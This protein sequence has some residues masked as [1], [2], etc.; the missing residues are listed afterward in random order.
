MIRLPD[1][2]RPWALMLLMLA[3]ATVLR[4]VLDP[5]LGDRAPFVTYYP[6]TV[7]LALYAGSWPAAASV[8]LSVIVSGLLFGPAEPVRSDVV[9]LAIYVPV[10][11]ALIVLIERVRRAGEEARRRERAARERETAAAEQ[12]AVLEAALQSVDAGVHSWDPETGEAQWDARLRTLFGLGH[13]EPATRDALLE[14]VHP[15]DRTRVE[16]AVLDATSPGGTRRYTV[17]FRVVRDDGDIRWISSA[18]FGVFDGD[19]LVRLVGTAR[20]VTERR[21][22]EA[23]LRESEQRFATLAEGS[24]V[25]LWVNG[26]AGN[27]FVNRAYREFVGVDS[28]EEISGNDWSRFVHPG[29]RADYFNA[30]QRAFA[31]EGQFTA[32]FRFR[33]RDGEYRW[34]RSDA[35]PRFGDDGELVGY[36]GATVD[37]TE[38]RSAED[39]LRLADRQKD[40]FLAMLAHELRNPLAPIRNASEVLALRYAGD[41]E[42]AVPIA[43]LRRQSEHL[44]RLLDD[45]LDVT[46]IAQGRVALKQQPLEIGT[47]VAQAIETVGPLAQQKSQLVRLERD[48]TPLYVSGDRARLVQSL[49]NVLQNSVKFTQQGGEIVV[50]VRDAGPDLELTVRDNGAGIAPDLVPRVF[51]L[52]VQSERTPDRSQGGLGIGLSVVKRLVEMHGGAVRVTSAGEGRG[53]TVT[54]RLPRIEPPQI[55]V[56]PAHAAS[57]ARRVLV[58]DDSADAADSL[59]MLLELEGHDVSTAYTAAAALDKAERLQPDVAFIDIGLPQMDGYEVARRLRASERCRAIRLVALTGYGQPDDRDEA[60][61]AGFDHHLV[62]PA[63]LESVDA[64]LSES[65]G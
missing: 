30:Y 4:G 18:G 44:A 60:R 17:E 34:M 48:E 3:A 45:L 40:E 31:V 38:R 59:A 7:F 52:F 63:D 27:E 37:I 13:D 57:A 23:A 26:P 64:I 42:A 32:E 41:P 15:A 1:A 62:K 35:T 47:I 65:G 24:P 20:D 6:L 5:V 58:V 11:V 61:R 53:T 50:G 19:R 8:A 49:T 12:R 22:V 29:D 55:V 56:R 36:V 46:R 33:R 25:L 16:R 54:I 10:N 21:R 51:E 39:A 14:H 28:D 2:V 43:M 9:A